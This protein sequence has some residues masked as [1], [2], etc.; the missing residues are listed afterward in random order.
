MSGTEAVVPDSQ[1]ATFRGRVLIID[2]DE[3]IRHLCSSIV[4]SAGMEPFAV[5]DG[6]QAAERLAGIR[7]DY[8]LLDV[9]LPGRSGMELLREIRV[10]FPSTRV[11]II[12]GYAAVD[13][14]VEAMKQGAYDYLAKPFSPKRLLNVLTGHEK[15]EPD[16]EPREEASHMFCGMVGVSGA[17]QQTYELIEKA[18]RSESTVLVEGESGTGKELVARAIHTRSNRAEEPFV[19]VD[20]G[21]IPPTLIESE[22]FGH[23]AGAYTD[24]KEKREGLLRSAGAGSVF[25]DEIGEL[26]QAVQ[27]KLPGGAG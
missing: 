24:A 17:M 25:L 11:V 16:R 23:T 21:A 4:S 5:A 9:N 1:D 20:C 14:A 7:P 10:R 27:V 18:A 3:G 12:T 2:D 15:S 6:E 13:K 19:P 22:L 8:V 26:P